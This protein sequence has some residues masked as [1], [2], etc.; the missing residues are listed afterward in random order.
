MEVAAAK[1]A[2]L[3]ASVA[4]VATAMDAAVAA[5]DVAL[6]ASVAATASFF[7]G[8]VCT[9]SASQI[10]KENNDTCTQHA[11]SNTNSGTMFE[12]PSNAE[13]ANVEVQNEEEHPEINIDLTETE[14]SD[15][16]L[17]D[18]V[19]NMRNRISKEHVDK[20]R[21]D[22][23][24][25]A[26]NRCSVSYFVEVVKST[27]KSARKV[28]LVRGIGFGFMLELDDCIVPRPFAKWIADNVSV[29]DEHILLN[30]K[31][32][33]LSAESV[34]HVLGIPAG[35]NT[36]NM[37]NDGGKADFLAFFEKTVKIDS[38]NNDYVSANGILDS[39]ATV[40]VNSH[41]EPEDGETNIMPRKKRKLSDEEERST[42][43]EKK[44]SQ[45][46]SGSVGTH[47]KAQQHL[48]GDAQNACTQT[49]IPEFV[50]S[51]S[52]EFEE[53]NKAI[54]KQKNSMN[55]ID[56]EIDHT[57]SCWAKYLDEA[58]KKYFFYSDDIPTF[59][60]FENN[61]DCGKEITEPE[62]WRPLD[63]DSDAY[64]RKIQAAKNNIPTDKDEGVYNSKTTEVEQG[65]NNTKEFQDDFS[66]M[67]K[68]IP[69]CCG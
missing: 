25:K 23:V 44:L 45:Q 57:Q 28:E 64:E 7:E 2:A 51:K 5:K 34:F 69:A 12:A 6:D 31:G 3:Y 43:K 61:D 62:L 38:S 29:K 11:G 21:G 24:A 30:N 4:A 52:F 39:D 36:I 8:H 54:Q 22:A 17:C 16:I 47:S 67:E 55:S 68:D 46:S 41:G 9:P 26:Y 1:D 66:S 20:G 53:T 15:G 56:D 10:E 40:K 27:T 65:T 58:R 60:L 48:V 13:D 32:I 50:Q 19:I 59:R 37:A 63:M 14:V 49:Y 33:T 35:E 18:D 42:K